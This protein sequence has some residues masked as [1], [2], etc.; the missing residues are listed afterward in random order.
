[1]TIAIITEKIHNAG[2]PKYS[3]LMN[4]F[5][6]IFNFMWCVKILQRSKLAYHC[7]NYGNNGIIL[8]SFNQT[9]ST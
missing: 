9:L 2:L 1:M 5:K 6:E 8:L 7:F 4:K 3:S